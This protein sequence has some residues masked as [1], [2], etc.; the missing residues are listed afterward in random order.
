[1]A[2]RCNRVRCDSR[3]SKGPRGTVGTDGAR[4][5]VRR[6][7]GDFRAR[8]SGEVGDTESEVTWTADAFVAA[9]PVR[10]RLKPRLQRHEVAL[11]RPSPQ[12]SV[13]ADLGAPPQ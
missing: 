8:L 12:E 3:S 2:R 1:M 11:R 13:T 10:R 9:A 7:A 6:P 4:G 5:G